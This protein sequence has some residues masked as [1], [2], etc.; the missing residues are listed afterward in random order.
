MDTNLQ[1]GA[2]FNIF[3]PGVPATSGSHKSFKGRITH[4]SD[5]TKRW[6]DAVA[7]CVL[8]KYGNHCC[9]DGPTRA[10][11]VFYLPRPKGHY[12]K[13]GL[14]SSAP[15]HPVVKPDL[16]KLVRAVQDALT[17]VLWRD[18][19]QIYEL[20]AEKRYT[21]ADAACGVQIYVL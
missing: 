2:D 21:E 18:D 13:K 14:K 9:Q 17:K 4:A 11:F 1:N 5:T 16:D 6:M 15:Q 8:E 12:S 20:R 19:S 10:R 7:W 3:V